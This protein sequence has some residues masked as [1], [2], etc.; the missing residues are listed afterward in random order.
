VIASVSV[1][2]FQTFM[3]PLQ[4][5]AEDGKAHSLAEAAEAPSTQL[6]L[7]PK[8]SPNACQADG[9]RGWL[10]ALAGRRHT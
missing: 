8:T 3:L 5:L 1:P 7:S 4:R 9:S 2:D 6:H 10:T